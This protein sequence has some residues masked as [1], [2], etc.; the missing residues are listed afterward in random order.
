MANALFRLSSGKTA[1]PIAQSDHG[2]EHNLQYIIEQNPDLLL[3]DQDVESGRHL[4]LVK[5]ELRLQAVNSADPAL[6]LDHFMV[7]DEG[8]PVLVEVKRSAN[9]ESRREVVGQM[10]DYAVRISAMD[11]SDLQEMY[12]ASNGTLAPSDDNRSFWRN[13]SFNLKSGRMRMVFAADSLPGSLKAIIELL[14]NAMPNIDVYGVEIARHET[15][16]EVFLTT[17]IV[18]SNAKSVSYTQSFRQPRWTE[19]SVKDLLLKNFGQWAPDVHDRIVQQMH[20][21]GFTTEYGNGALFATFYIKYNGVYL[22]G[23][24]GD[25]NYYHFTFN[26]DAIQQMTHGATSRS[27]LVESVSSL[28]DGSKYQTFISKKRIKFDFGSFADDTCL[29]GILSIAEE[30]ASSIHED[31]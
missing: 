2:N 19:T 3:R 29:D 15:G 12:E 22:M 8:I 5:R 14:D 1:V 18:Q 13:V 28:V 9:P 31:M 4:H 7:D 16:G 17:N 27:Y 26:T 24:A 30:I 11:S 10:M 21:L 25:S 20:E 6:S 23:A